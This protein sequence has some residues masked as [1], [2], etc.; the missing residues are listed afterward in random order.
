[1]PK[2]LQPL[3]T[4]LE[5]R[6]P[7]APRVLEPEASSDLLQVSL[8]YLKGGFRR[9]HVFIMPYPVC[10][11]VHKI[12]LQF[13]VCFCSFTPHVVSYLFFCL[14]FSSSCA[15]LSQVGLLE[16]P[17]AYRG[18]LGYFFCSESAVA[19][20]LLIGKAIANGR[21]R[22]CSLLSLVPYPKRVHFASITLTA[23]Y[24]GSRGR[25]LLSKTIIITWIASH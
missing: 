23:K 4:L 24:W 25:M 15:I 2:I 14:A 3:T 21:S 17:T 5:G 7:Q 10:I 11:Y 18:S 6:A 8:P 19:E 16:V 20:W 9:C 12:V 22:V 13:Y 1:V